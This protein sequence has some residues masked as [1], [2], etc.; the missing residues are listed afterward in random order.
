MKFLLLIVGLIWAPYVNASGYFFNDEPLAFGEGKKTFYFPQGSG[1][2]IRMNGDKIEFTTY[3]ST[4]DNEIPYNMFLGGLSGISRSFPLPDPH[5][6]FTGGSRY[7]FY[8]TVFD[9]AES[10]SFEA[11]NEIPVLRKLVMRRKSKGS[12]GLCGEFD[13]TKPFECMKGVQDSHWRSDILSSLGLSPY[14]LIEGADVIEM[15]LQQ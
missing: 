9:D 12:I 10:M 4:S 11:P 13:F 6:A 3:K 5:Y 1:A 8:M 15:Y 14:F 2:A 7:Q